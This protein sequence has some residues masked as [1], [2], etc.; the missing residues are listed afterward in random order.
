MKVEGLTR[1]DEGRKNEDISSINIPLDPKEIFEGKPFSLP[2][3][4]DWNVIYHPLSRS[5]LIVRIS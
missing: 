1:E 2:I 3:P 5:K 4:I